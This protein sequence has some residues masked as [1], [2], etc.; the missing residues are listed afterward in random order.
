KISKEEMTEILEEATTAP[1]SVN[2]QPWRFIVID[3]PEGKEK[4]APLARF[5]QTHVTTSSAVLAV[6]ADM[7]NADYLEEIYSTAVEL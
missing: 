1:T 4:L 3:S 5:N 2:A 7:Y 6:F